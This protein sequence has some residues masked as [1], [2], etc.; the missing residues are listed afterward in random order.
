MSF[1]HGVAMP[2]PMTAT[3]FGLFLIFLFSNKFIFFY[4]YELSEELS[5]QSHFS[6]LLCSLPNI[7]ICVW[8]EVEDIE[9]MQGKQSPPPLLPVQ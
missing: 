6:T 2:N 4:S 5:C 8:K 9:K 1:E 7:Y 3:K